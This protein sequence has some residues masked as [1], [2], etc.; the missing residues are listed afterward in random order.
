VTDTP[1]E[2]SGMG[3]VAF[4]A[5][6]GSW[7]SW[8]RAVG[9]SA[10]H[11]WRILVYSPLTLIF[12]VWFLLTLAISI[13]L[14]ADFYASD[15]ATFDLQWTFLPW[16]A[17]VMVPAL[18][19]RAFAESEGDRGLEL[20]LSLPLPTSAL[21]TG[22]WLAGTGVLMATL[23]MTAPFAVTVG[24]LGSPDWGVAIAGYLGAALLLSTYFAVALL[25]ATM[26]RDPA[27]SYVVAL[28]LLSVLLLLGWDVATRALGDGPAAS[29]VAQFVQLSPKYWLDRMA[30]GRIELAGVAYFVALIVLAISAASAMVD[31][32]RLPASGET[33]RLKSVLALTAAGI[34]GVIVL[35]L[36]TRLPLAL[37]MTDEREF[38]L[39]PET[40][41]IAADAPEGTTVD[42]YYSEDESRIPASIRAHAR[43][44]KAL[45]RRIRDVSN[46]RITVRTNRVTEDSEA[47][48]RALSAGVRPVPMTSGDR[49][50]LGATFSH[51]ERQG[52]VSYFDERRAQLL[53]YDLAL[54]LGSLGQR[55]V[56][57]V[58]VLSPLL[59]A[60][61]ITEPR[62]G[63]AMLEELKRQYD[64]AI[65][66]HF[67]DALPPDL[68]AVVVIDAPVLKRSMLYSIDQHVMAGGGLIVMV[69]PF[70]RFNRANTALSPEPGDAINDITDL[71]ARYGARYLGGTVI[72]DPALAA[73]VAGGDGQQL[74]YPFWLRARNRSLSSEH[75]VT[76][77]LNEVL[78]AEAGAFALEGE[79]ANAI[80]LLKTGGD[81][82]ALERGAFKNATAQALAAGFQADG[83]GA[84]AIGVALPG[85]HTSAF[86]QPPE[87]H[88]GGPHNTGGRTASSVFA[89]ADADWLFDPMALQD[90]QVG[91]Q[92][93]T[94]PLNDNTTLLMNM[95]EFA[96]GDPRLIGI[97]SRGKIQRP[98]TRVSQMLAD[99][100]ARYRSEESQQMARITKVEG[101]IA[102]VLE[103]TGATSVEQ[104]PKSLRDQIRDLRRQLLPF[105]RDLRD[106]RRRIREDIT[107]LGER[108]TLANL[109]AGPSLAIGW[110]VLLWRT[111]RRR[112]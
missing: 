109:I 22:K 8:F 5:G 108:I 89:V 52:A 2:G 50:M 47:E 40:V 60:S 62:D 101:N 11:E 3:S 71:L 76:A 32:R 39:H 90:V 20:A 104:L 1:G 75:P 99:A 55:N 43:R 85:P 69:D 37:D 48:E 57:R 56:P 17:L 30:Q 24:Y 64:V 105:R 100:Q 7:P 83:D 51:G 95:I 111:R 18:S 92:S 63:L 21:V 28:A 97:R 33:A 80:A 79:A 72:G 87:G 12:Q 103:T 14:I 67:A 61:N 88:E 34:G 65:V 86:A 82:G 27:G 9:A 42:I 19:M 31:R 93:I 53:E 45:A 107:R 102:K 54:A 38:T 68:D 91:S 112:Q 96:T 36:A 74:A 84:R 110:A 106:I 46:R 81:S 58:G 16:V 35:L 94:R 49:F 77:S 10:R 59:K 26:T 66:P 23:A 73:P 44:V 70:P 13:F 29:L 6:D 25:A 78:L 41:R 15:L 98:F 4:G